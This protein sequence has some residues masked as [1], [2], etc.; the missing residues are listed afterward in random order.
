[1]DDGTK[2]SY[3]DIEMIDRFYLLPCLVDNPPK[4][5]N[6]VIAVLRR[7]TTTRAR[8]IHLIFDQKADRN[9]LISG[10]N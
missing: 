7:I 8:E 5:G 3:S 2:P 4:F 1:M 10:P 6:T 9:F